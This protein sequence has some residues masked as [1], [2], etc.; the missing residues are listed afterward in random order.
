VKKQN[1]AY[2]GNIFYNCVIYHQINIF[3][4]IC[5][6][7]NACFNYENPPN[8]KAVYTR[9]GI[10]GKYATFVAQIFRRSQSAVPVLIRQPTVAT[11][12]EVWSSG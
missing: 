1:N 6:R 8:N 12:I 9:V 4:E 7:R 5:L 11:V 2:N 3:L 10:V